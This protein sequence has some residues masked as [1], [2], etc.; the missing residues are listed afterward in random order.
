MLLSVWLLENRTV[1]IR[2]VRR[3]KNS[4]KKLEGS[5]KDDISRVAKNKVARF[6]R[7]LDQTQRDRQTHTHTTH[8]HTHTHSHTCISLIHHTALMTTGCEKSHLTLHMTNL[9]S[10][11]NIIQFQNH[12]HIHS[13]IK[14]KIPKIINKFM[15]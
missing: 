1:L 5:E 11:I 10:I 9:H 4:R 3:N 13:K 6:L 15:I 8:T 12:N 14:F 7:F 2:R